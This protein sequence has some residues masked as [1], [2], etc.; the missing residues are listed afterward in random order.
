VD[1][2]DF[3]VTIEPHP[4]LSQTFRLF[5]VQHGGRFAETNSLTSR[6]DLHGVSPLE[7][8]STRAS[9]SQIESDSGLDSKR[10]E[11]HIYPIRIISPA[12]ELPTEIRFSFTSDVLEDRLAD[13]ETA[14][15]R[16]GHPGYP[17]VA[18]LQ[19][20]VREFGQELFEV[21]LPPEARGLFYQSRREAELAGKGL[22]VKLQIEPPELATLPWELLY[23]PRQA[24]FV[25]LS[26]TTPIV[27]DVGLAQP[28]QPL[29]V[30]GPLRI[31]GM[32]A[33]PHGFAPLDIAHEQERVEDALAGLQASEVIE[34]HWLEGSSWYHLQQEISRHQFHVFHFIGHGGFNVD[35]AEGLIVLA[36]DNGEPYFL[37]ADELAM[38]LADE[39]ALRLVLLNACEGARG[40]RR[41]VFSSTATTL[42]R[43]G[44]PAVLAMQ[45]EISDQ[46]AVA[47]ARAFYGALA[48]GHPI[49]AAVAES[50]KA[51]RLTLPGTLEWAT[52]VLYQR[53]PDGVLFNLEQPAAPRRLQREADQNTASS[54]SSEQGPL[55]PHRSSVLPSWLNRLPHLG[56]RFMA[57]VTALG[58]I[59]ALAVAVVQL[60]PDPQRTLAGT[61]SEVQ[62]GAR[63]VTLEEMYD[64]RPELDPAA[65]GL[66]E[67]DLMQ[68]GQLVSYRVEFEG[69]EDKACYVRWTLYDAK[70]GER[71][72]NGTGGWKTVHAAAWP[73][74]RWTIE[75]IERDVGQGEIWVP[76]VAPGR[77]VVEIEL[78]DND[79][80]GQLLDTERAED[81]EGREDV[82][83]VES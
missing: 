55:T 79:E 18:S 60:W 39:P 63:N 49:D 67:P 17:E 53:A 78:Y 23:D 64:D 56:K 46:A 4:D 5:G 36:D 77:Y 38:L 59:A 45:F 12:G 25:G 10:I 35:S 19:R 8:S 41:D 37:R 83:M 24:A 54:N 31:L 42:V 58:T 74:G 68:R 22:R 51:V 72:P 11:D 52:P 6:R 13:V 3:D 43:R 15:L 26:T 48:D 16:S 80:G 40:D 32:V 7:A 14:V 9:S 71:V 34:L 65:D 70:T 20:K 30:A 76:H 27:R 69:L 57:V 2:L 47:L 28:I 29:T 1:Y 61:L 33:S 73:D 75:V 66:D 62:L 44:I 50:R 81:A 82:F 21:L